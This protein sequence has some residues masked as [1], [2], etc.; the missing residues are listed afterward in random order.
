MLKL[1]VLPS[2]VHNPWTHRRWQTEEQT[3]KQRTHIHVADHGLPLPHQHVLV[4]LFLLLLLLLCG[5][6]AEWPKDPGSR[7]CEW[8][9][10]PLRV[11]PAGNTWKCA[12]P[13]GL[14]TL[15]TQRMDPLTPKWQV[16]A[17]SEAGF[18]ISKRNAPLAISLRPFCNA[19][20]MSPEIIQPLKFSFCNTKPSFSQTQGWPIYSWLDKDVRKKSCFL[21]KKKQPFL[22]YLLSSTSLAPQ[23]TI[24]YIRPWL[25]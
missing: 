17:S 23:N 15:K 6:G 12:P 13:G 25:G 4:F 21:K 18:P 16:A 7:P 20:E 22:Q 11:S 1:Y 10:S 8:T 9:S 19:W 24:I 2:C 14:W 5:Q 3:Q